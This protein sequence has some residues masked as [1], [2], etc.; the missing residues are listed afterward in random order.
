M[1]Q[2]LH[3]RRLV[4]LLVFCLAGHWLF[5]QVNVS[6]TVKDEDGNPLAGVTV[7]QENVNNSTLTNDQGNFSIVLRSEGNQSLEFT[8]IG[9]AK[10]VVSVSGETPMMITL[11]KDA[12]SLGEVVVVGYTSVKK[13]NVTGAVSTVPMADIEKR[14]VPLVSQALQGQ[15]AGVQVT[16]STGAPGDDINIRIRGEGTIGNNN[17]LFIVD[18]VPSRDINFLNPSDIKSMTVLKDASAAAVYGSRASAGVV[19]ITTLQGQSGKTTVDL[20]MFYGVQKAANLPK[21]LNSTQYIDK[22]EEAWNNSGYP[23]TNPYTGEKG[24]ADFA[25]TDWLDELFEP[26]ISQNIQLTASGGN[27][28]TRYLMSVGYYNQDGIVIFNN[29]QLRRYNFRLN[30]NTNLTDRLVAGTNFQV[31]KSIQDKLSSKGDAPGI[32]RH[33]L[34][35]PPVIPV[36]KDEND[37]TY[38]ADDP[39]T[40]LPFYRGVTQGWESNK[41]EWTSNPI[42]LAYFANDK[43]NSFRTFGN[44]YGEYSLLGDKSLK[45]RSSLGIDLN[46]L[47]NKAFHMNFGDDDGG[48]SDVDKGMGRQNRPNGLNE[49]RGEDFTLTWNNTL[50]YIKSFNR[51]SFNALAGTEFIKNSSSAISASRMRYEFD[52]PTSR[53]IDFGG[54]ERD[55]WNGGSGAEWALFSVFG[56]LNYSYDA[57]YMLTANIRADASSRFAEN[58]RWGYFPSISA[59]WTISEE[60]FMQD[61]QWISDLRLRASTGVL[62]NQEIDNYAFMTLLR[63]DGDKYV[64]HRYGNPDLK[65]E[66]TRQD[67][68]G[69]DLG[70]V[71]NKFYL[72]LDYFIKNTSGILLPVSLPRIIGDVRPTYINAGEVKNKGFEVAVSYR[73][74]QGA[75]RYNIN[76]NLAT[77]T[78]NVEK[79]HP[80]LPN[81]MGPVTKT[82]AGHPLNAYYGYRMEGIYQ[83]Q[84]EIEKHLFGTVS[85]NEKPGDIKFTDVDGNGIINDNDRAFIGSPIPELTYGLNFSAEYKGFDLSFLFQG[86]QGVDR[87]NDS[88]KILDYDTRP[89]NHTVRVLDSWNGEGSTNS[90][91]RVSFTDNG[92]SKVSNIFIEDASYMRLKNIEL[93]YSLTG[94]NKMNIGIRQL[95]VYVSAQN[96]FTITD[97]TGM[98]PESVDLMDMGTYPQSRAF[99]FGVNAKF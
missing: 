30:L 39:F 79:L 1:N 52:R 48:G 6:G 60:D 90:I 98:D 81:I 69:V 40:D 47:H 15:V 19:V 68:F 67:N 78:N 4:L 64:I 58:N 3:P 93:G 41:Y 92:S 61:V 73:E 66:S 56:S 24:R 82:M 12:S 43:R 86:V 76:A 18:G 38:S 10:Q 57:K 16:Q 9:F 26:G 44:I 94:I 87:Y 2:T 80:N 27:E 45:F 31:S 7:S 53:Y 97:Y 13:S 23:G 50:N 99:I 65:W 55:I 83:N 32:I 51:H 85:P 46:Y 63:K 28:K 25:N 5:A 75:F 88:K 37:P 36:Y 62:G 84:A 71:R 34:L 33:A 77:L 8:N 89:F 17:P 72:S 91:P 54:T 42:A 14:R 70:L 74:N 96:V 21:M 20:N 49:E 35:R 95:R 29:D 22:L 11:K 59:G